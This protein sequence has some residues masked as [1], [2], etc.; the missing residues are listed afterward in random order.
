MFR[1]QT[2]FK[3]S[4]S[5]RYQINATCSTSPLPG[6]P[7]LCCVCAFP[8][9][10]CVISLALIH[11]VR[12]GLTTGGCCCG[13]IVLWR[14]PPCPQVGLISVCCIIICAAVKCANVISRHVNL[15][16][17]SH[18]GRRRPS[19]FPPQAG[20]ERTRCCKWDDFF[21][22]SSSSPPRWWCSRVRR[23]P[24]SLEFR[25][26]QLSQVTWEKLNYTAHT[27]AILF[28]FFFFF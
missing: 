17:E 22:F 10:V 13:Q 9:I 16:D 14:D 21:F 19:A 7:M 12:S 1:L 8:Y 4:T 23:Q 5:L 3:V 27:F 15:Q 6:L 28:L 18:P 11:Y 2:C 24:A 20:A 25:E 26:Q